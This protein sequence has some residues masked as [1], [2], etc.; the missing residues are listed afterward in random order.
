MT[1]S[2]L[3]EL[4]TYDPET[5]FIK[6]KSY[7]RKSMAKHGESDGHQHSSGYITIMVKG[8]SYLAHRLVW[9]YVT[10]NMPE[11]QIDHINGVRNDNRF[12]NLREVT[13]QQNSFNREGK[14]IALDKKTGKFMAGITVNGKRIYIGYYKTEAEAKKAYIEA[15]KKYHGKEFIGRVT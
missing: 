8:K 15:K 1:Q 9:F 12:S 11:N 7:R 10:G 3:K 14:G 13:H 4:I 2:E 6:W 5:G